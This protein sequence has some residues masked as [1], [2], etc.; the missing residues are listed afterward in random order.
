MSQLWFPERRPGLG[1]Q[2]GES[3]PNDICTVNHNLGKVV[4]VGGGSLRNLRRDFP[5][6]SLFNPNHTLQAFHNLAL[7]CTQRGNNR[8]FPYSSLGSNS[9]QVVHSQAPNGGEPYMFVTLPYFT[10]VGDTARWGYCPHSQYELS[11]VSGFPLPSP[12]I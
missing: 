5:A 7:E 10:L 12:R 2:V 3:Q 4:V 6:Y 1:S 11:R 8:S 9:L